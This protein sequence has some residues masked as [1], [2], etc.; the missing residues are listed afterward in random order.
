VTTCDAWGVL[1]AA[2]NDTAA[3]GYSVQRVAI[4]TQTDKSWL[5]LARRGIKRQHTV[6][7]PAHRRHK[8]TR[9]AVSR[10]LNRL[11]ESGDLTLIDIAAKYKLLLYTQ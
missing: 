8:R 1:S 3:A 10:F 7:P 4:Y 5:A 11:E 6:A 2:L 9:D